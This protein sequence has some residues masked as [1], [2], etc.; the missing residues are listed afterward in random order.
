MSDVTRMT[1][2]GFLAAGVLAL[3][4]CAQSQDKPQAEPETTDAPTDEGADVVDSQPVDD[5]AQAE[6][7]TVEGSKILVAY[8]SRADENYTNGGK[9]WL[10]VGHTKVM[11]GYI[12]EAL[13]ADTYEIAPVE[14]YPEGYDDCCDVA[15]EEQRDDA[16]PAIAGTLPDVSPYDTVVIGCPIWWGDEPMIVRTFIE[17]VDLS[18]KTIVPFTTHGGSGLGRV[19]SNL[20]SLLPEAHFFDGYAVA[21]TDVDGAYDEVVNW[22][23]GLALA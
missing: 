18:G 15:L 19:P 21:G 14:P 10:E 20:Q 13:G 22:A 16:R 12:A 11:A 23:K 8:Y 3:A 7:E 9:E 4:A 5:E 2:R 1:R 17:G 6:A